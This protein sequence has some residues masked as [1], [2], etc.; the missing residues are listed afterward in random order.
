M[1]VDLSHIVPVVIQGGDQRTD[2]GGLVILLRGL[3]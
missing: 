2:M 1:M 3:P